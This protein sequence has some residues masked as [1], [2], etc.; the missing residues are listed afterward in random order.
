MLELVD[1]KVY[2]HLYQ[3]IVLNKERTVAKLTFSAFLDM[4]SLGFPEEFFTS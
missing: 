3:D 1:R 4:V 2:I